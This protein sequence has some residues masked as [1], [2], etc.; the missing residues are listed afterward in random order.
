MRS[1][2]FSPGPSVFN[3]GLSMTFRFDPE[4]LGFAGALFALVGGGLAMAWGEGA[5]ASKLWAAGTAG[6]A[7]RLLWVIVTSLRQGETGLD[8]IAALAMGGALVLGEPLAGAIVALMYA[9]G[10]MLERYARNRAAGA[11]RALV[12]RAPRTAET[13]TAEGLVSVPVESVVAGDR[14]YVRPGEVIPVDGEV[15][16]G[17]ALVDESV[18]TG[19]SMPVVREEDGGVISGSVNAGSAFTMRAAR[20]A[21]ESAYAGI[22][23]LV[24]TAQASKAPF[25]R[26][27]ERYALG[28][29]AVTLLLAG[30]GW[31]FSGD[32]RRALAVLVVATPCPLILAV[33]VALVAGL[34]RTAKLGLLVKTAA[35]LEALG[36]VGTV[37][38]D[39]TG[40]LTAGRP[41][42]AVV[43]P[44]APWSEAE[45]LLLAGALAQGSKHVVSAATADA[46]RRRGL[47][48][49]RPDAVEEIA[50]E[51]VAGIVAGRTVVIGG[52][53]FV[54][55]MI[56][57]PEDLPSPDHADL[58]LW[59]AVDGAAAGAVLFT[60]PIRPEA[61]A[62]LAAFRA[63]GVNRIVLVTG[64]RRE[65]ALGIT[66]GLPV[67]EVIADVSPAGKVEAVGAARARHG[68]VVMIGDG[69]N[70][71][72]ALAAAD[73][74][75]ALAGRGAGASSEAADAVLVGDRL[76]RIPAAFAVAKRT[77]AIA[78]QS[79]VAGI[80]L[81]VAAMVAA[82]FGLITPVAG[83][84]LQE[85]IDVAV[86]LN[87]LRALGPVGRSGF[88]AESEFAPAA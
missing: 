14:V 19:E 48:L 71:A 63:A 83:A 73:V 31:F 13:V 16:H 1:A 76:D 58:G 15:E 43:V 29:L 35:A 24:E 17:K 36:R 62:A 51:G 42:V 67:D 70:D 54:G 25:T 44:C 82:A 11:I 20:P 85:A 79:V 8:I 46:A 68:T 30:A 32:P 45:L 4:P 59:I 81:S 77:V 22:V 47:A 49:P 6:V 57:R 28:F 50:G 27:A 10:Q 12:S 78:R 65:V 23:R 39:K 52:R 56:E 9:G 5:L 86:I 41:E 60:D 75:I 21:S 7:L 72:P 69:I 53:D 64:D 61:A 18:M 33:P 2:C 40:T 66:A 38:I 87:A 74:G 37:L 3:A 80:A 55:R 26:M 34:S 88:P 84:L